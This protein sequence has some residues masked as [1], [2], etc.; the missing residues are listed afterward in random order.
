MF[1]PEFAENLGLTPHT[2]RFYEKAGLLDKRY[3]KRGQN[4]YRHYSQEAIERVVTIKLLQTAGFTLSEIKDHLERWDAGELTT[5]N[6]AM[7]LRQK[8]DEIEGKIAELEQVK[9]SL[10][11]KITRIDRGTDE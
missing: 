10:M 8:L 2:I 9:A 3:I 7:I 1:I 11:S 5:H 4:R 6:Q